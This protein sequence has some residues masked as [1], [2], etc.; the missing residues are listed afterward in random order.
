M[1]P[2]P[3]SPSVL[4]KVVGSTT[5]LLGLALLTY[6]LRMYS[7]VVPYWNLQWDDHV[8]TLAVIVTIIN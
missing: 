8:M 7:R 6:G 4:P 1:G 2:P 3:T 5:I